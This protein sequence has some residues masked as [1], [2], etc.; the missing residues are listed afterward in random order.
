MYEKALRDECGYKGYQP[1][2]AFH[3]VLSGPPKTADL[4]CQYMNY[5]RYAAD[6]VNSPMFNGN[7]SSMGGQG[8]YNNYTGVPQ[9]FKK[10][11]DKIP[12]AGGGGCVM[13]GPFKK[14]VPPI[15]LA[16]FSRGCRAD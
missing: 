10:P 7:A 6:P 5:D 16:T 15:R 8:A 1:V 9:P 4:P 2:S 13:D 3:R 14:Y 12:P 11:L